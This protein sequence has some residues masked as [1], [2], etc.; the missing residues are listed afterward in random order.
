MQ[1][2]RLILTLGTAIRTDCPSRLRREQCSK[3]GAFLGV[4]IE[5]VFAKGL[6]S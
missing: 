6:A 5:E 3:A 4:G 1:P 2:T